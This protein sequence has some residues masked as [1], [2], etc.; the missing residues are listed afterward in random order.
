MQAHTH[1]HFCR[2][3]APCA[4]VAWPGM[5]ALPCT[6]T[7]IAPSLRGGLFL[8]FQLSPI[9]KEAQ[10][11]TTVSAHPRMGRYLHAPPCALLWPTHPLNQPPTFAPP[12]RAGLFMRHSSH[13]GSR[14]SGVGR[15]S[16]FAAA[17]AAMLISL[18]SF[19]A[20]ISCACTSTCSPVCKCVCVRVCACVCVRERAQARICVPVHAHTCGRA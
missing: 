17:R 4:C 2:C 20:L 7:P 5:H 12:L 3:A 1:V 13:S 6:V 8:D 18:N 19:S 15:A 10:Q 16:R 9:Q 14:R 11:S